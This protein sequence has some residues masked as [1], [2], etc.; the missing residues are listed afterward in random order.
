MQ[1]QYDFSNTATM[2]RYHLKLPEAVAGDEPEIVPPPKLI[3]DAIVMLTD[4]NKG[5][6]IYWDGARYRRYPVERPLVDSDGSARSLAASL[7]CNEWRSAT[8]QLNAT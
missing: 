4:E 1:T 7:F 2:K 6:A 5:T 3:G 8:Q